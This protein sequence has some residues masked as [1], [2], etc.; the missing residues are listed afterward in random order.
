MSVTDTTTPPTAAP[1]ADPVRAALGDPHVLDRLRQAVRG[2][3]YG[4]L[5]HV[6]EVVQE[7]CTRAL[8]KKD[9]YDA[10][11][12]GVV[13][14]LCGLVTY[15]V[16]EHRRRERKQPHQPGD[17]DLAEL[18]AARPEDDD[19]AE[20]IRLAHA[21]VATLDGPD[22]EIIT[23]FHFEKLPHAQI[24]KRLGITVTAARKRYSR[25]FKTMTNS[26]HASASGERQ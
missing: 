22:R 4:G 14:W 12:G 2:V 8:E 7:V 3:Y 17:V 21:Y 19:A 6:D 10:A 9:K 25:A 13:A 11:K 26:A 5:P 23:M 1:P 24:A 16:Y 20:V 15:I 18:V